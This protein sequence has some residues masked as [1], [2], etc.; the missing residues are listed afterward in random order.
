MGVDGP[1]VNNR[2]F[3]VFPFSISSAL[4][5]LI[6]VMF[7]VFLGG[8]IFHFDNLSLSFSLLPCLSSPWAHDAPHA[9]GGINYPLPG[10]YEPVYHL[11]S[12]TPPPPSSSLS[13]LSLSSS[14]P[15]P[16][17]DKTAGI[18][19]IWSSLGRSLEEAALAK[20]FFPSEALA[21]SGRKEATATK[22]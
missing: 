16:P 19:L 21:A 1:K 12:D 8:S 4:L 6:R 2:Y 10:S 20:R 14:R 13:S 5:S 18:P 7:G 15:L 11:R 9:R 17:A 3:S 22:V